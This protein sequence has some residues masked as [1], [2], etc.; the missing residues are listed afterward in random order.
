MHHITS[1]TS[2]SSNL[3][4]PP[5]QPKQIFWTHLPHPLATPTC[6]THLPHPLILQLTHLVHHLNT[7]T[8]HTHLPHPLATH[9]T[10]SSTHLSTPLPHPLA[11]PTYIT[12]KA[13]CVTE[14][15]CGSDV[16][17]IQ[18]K[19][20]Q[21]GDE[22]CTNFSYGI[23]SCDGRKFVLLDLPSLPFSLPSLPLFSFPPSS[24]LPL[25]LS[26][27]SL[28]PSLSPLPLSLSSLPPPSSG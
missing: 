17:G 27:P 4:H 7:P 22:V 10:Y 3:C 19:A 26:S 14:P 11:T 16:N 21:K 8:Y 15:G 6:H 23:P 13:Y 18:T 25:S 12:T 5:F 28:P 1:Y 20:V 2:Y 9:T 24:L